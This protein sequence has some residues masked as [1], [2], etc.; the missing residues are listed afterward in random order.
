MNNVTVTAMR[1]N[2]AGATA[3]IAAMD[4][5]MEDLRASAWYRTSLA[6][7]RAEVEAP[8]IA[9][10]L[11][12]A[13]KF[14]RTQKGLVDGVR[15]AWVPPH[16]VQRKAALG[17]PGRAN[18]IAE[19]V[20]RSPPAEAEKI[21]RL[22]VEDGDAGAAYALRMAV[23]APDG[24]PNAAAAIALRAGTGESDEALKVLLSAQRE[25]AR[26]IAVAEKDP[27]RWLS[28]AHEAEVVA[29][30]DGKSTQFSEAQI[31]ELIGPPGA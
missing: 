23:E 10:R 29:G 12:A 3:R 15:K 5:E 17:N 22:L 7:V 9:A 19:L 8:M 30:E 16:A 1:S 11:D 2:R 18:A 14:L 28:A 6:P 26:S 25:Y 4:K 21:A 27:V 24:T 31:S 20:R 13:E